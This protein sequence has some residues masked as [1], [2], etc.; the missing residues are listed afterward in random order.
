MVIC[1][2]VD[3]VKIPLMTDYAEVIIDFFDFMP[4]GTDM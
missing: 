1:Q 2:W 3:G 4:Y